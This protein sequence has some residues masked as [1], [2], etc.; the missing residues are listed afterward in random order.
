MPE[1]EKH[2]EIG[3]VV[4]PEIDQADLT[5]PF[6]VLSKLPNSTFV[7]LAEETT[8]VRDMK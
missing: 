2:L 8:P 1:S 5:G 7:V 4:F 3:A 6:E